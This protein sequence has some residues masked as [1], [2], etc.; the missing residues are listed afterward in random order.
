MIKINNCCAVQKN[1]CLVDSNR[2]IRELSFSFPKP[3]RA[4]AFFSGSASG[5]NIPCFQKLARFLDSPSNKSYASFVL[6]K[7][8][9]STIKR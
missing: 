6:S 9:A 7:L 1:L 8:P 3:H 4:E 2:R 5:R